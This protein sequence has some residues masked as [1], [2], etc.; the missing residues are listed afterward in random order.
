MSLGRVAAAAWSARPATCPFL[1][2]AE[3]A[4]DR[5]TSSKYTPNR[6]SGEL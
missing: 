1:R 6:R 2:P 3:E 5:E 4:I